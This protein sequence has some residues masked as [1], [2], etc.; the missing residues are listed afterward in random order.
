MGRNKQPEPVYTVINIPQSNQQ[1]A[2]V[3]LFLVAV[4]GG[5]VDIE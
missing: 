1:F 4:Q 5:D 3:I 2:D